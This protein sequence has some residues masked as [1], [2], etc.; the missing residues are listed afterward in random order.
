MNPHK[1]VKSGTAVQFTLDWL[2]GICYRNVKILVKMKNERDR[3]SD[4]FF[5]ESTVYYKSGYLKKKRT[6]V[7]K[8]IENRADIVYNWYT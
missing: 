1:L 4:R 8:N 7:L 3:C 6:F 2:V 5:M